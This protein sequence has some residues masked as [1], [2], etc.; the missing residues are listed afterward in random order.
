MKWI[1]RK[2]PMHFQ[3][4]PLIFTLA[5]AAVAG[6]M[7]EVGHHTRRPTTEGDTFF[8]T[9]I[10]VINCY[11]ASTEYFQNLS[12]RGWTACSVSHHLLEMIH[13]CLLKHI[14]NVHAANRTNRTIVTMN[15]RPKKHRK[16]EHIKTH[17]TKL[18]AEWCKWRVAT[19]N[20]FR[21]L[22]E[23]RMQ[24]RPTTNS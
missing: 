4:V 11:T 9:W 7:F 20:K 22:Y 13:W 8:S 14:T 21:R 5:Q 19:A 23:A 2:C 3:W 6:G 1:A 24:S 18:K 16:N 17:E 12:Q 15:Q 10:I